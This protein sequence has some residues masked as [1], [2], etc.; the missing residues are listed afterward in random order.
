M[1][2]YKN[3]GYTKGNEYAKKYGYY[4]ITIIKPWLILK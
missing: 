3:C 1:V 2:L 4:T